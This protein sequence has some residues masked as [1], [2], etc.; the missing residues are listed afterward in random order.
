VRCLW[1]FIRVKVTTHNLSYRIDVAT[2][3]E[4]VKFRYFYNRQTINQSFK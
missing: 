2:S 1:R 4:R 3:T